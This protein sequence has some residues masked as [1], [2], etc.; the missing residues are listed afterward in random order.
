MK[1]LTRDEI[2]RLLVVVDNIRDK[3]LIQLG[4][5]MGCR[6]SEVVGIRLK[7]VSADR[8]KL[9]DEKKD[10]FREVV[11]DSETKALLDEYLKSEWKPEPHVAHRV[12]Y[13]CTKTANRILKSWCKKAGIP[14][15]KAHFHVLRHSYVIHSLEAGVPINFVCEQTGDSPNTIIRIYGR[16]SIDSRRQM[17]DTIGAYWKV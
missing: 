2:K 3:L 6:V 5:V 16:P 15:D 10:L 8:I 17:A 13:F 1:Y 9:W 4:L 12:F 7:N 14:N 11:I